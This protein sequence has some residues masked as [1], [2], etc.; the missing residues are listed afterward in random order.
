MERREWRGCSL[1][2]SAGAALATVQTAQI[3]RRTL[4]TKRLRARLSG[5]NSTA[6]DTYPIR[7]RSNE[8]DAVA[9]VPKM[10]IVPALRR[11]NS[12]ASFSSVVLPGPLELWPAPSPR[13]RKFVY[14]HSGSFRHARKYTGPW[15]QTGG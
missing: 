15:S 5:S 8:P 14:W 12:A 11:N 7:A 3:W 13:C 6:C 1:R 10:R 4:P 9:S 2:T